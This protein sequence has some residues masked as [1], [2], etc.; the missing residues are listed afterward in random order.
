MSASPIWITLQ[1]LKDNL[2]Y[3]PETGIFTRLIANSQNTKVGDQAGW[4]T[5]LGYIELKIDGVHYKAHRLA[6]FYMTGIYPADDVDHVN[7]N[8]SDNRFANL[9]SATRSQNQFNKAISSK[10]KTGF[11]GVSFHKASQKFVAQGS[12][13]GKSYHLGVFDDAEEASA[14]YQSFA[15]KN[16][17]EFFRGK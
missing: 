17:G 2:E 15:K 10:N 7:L 12:F 3:N 13:Q 1:H 14:A 11:K 6:I 4:K 16:H 9:R 5:V 8:R